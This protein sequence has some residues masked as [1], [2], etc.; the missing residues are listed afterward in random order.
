M[1]CGILRKNSKKITVA[2]NCHTYI[3]S[4]HQIKIQSHQIKIATSI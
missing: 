4:L 3:F 2:H 1:N